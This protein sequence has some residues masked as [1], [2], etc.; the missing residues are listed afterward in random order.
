M[1]TI[2]AVDLGKYN[3]VFCWFTHDSGEVRFRSAEDDPRDCE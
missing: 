2:L 3:S 1:S